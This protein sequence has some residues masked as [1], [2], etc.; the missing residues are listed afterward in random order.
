M[1]ALT[2][3]GYG[4]NDRQ[5]AHDVV[6]AFG[7]VVLS[8]T[9]AQV[10]TPLGSVETLLLECDVPDRQFTRCRL[11]LIGADIGFL[12]PLIVCEGGHA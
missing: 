9:P 11:A 3:H 8:E 7:G 10:R 4:P 2:I 1:S 12:P 5:N 6:A